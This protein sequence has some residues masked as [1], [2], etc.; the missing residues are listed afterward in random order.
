MLTFGSLFSKVKLVTLELTYILLFNFSVLCSVYGFRGWNLIK[1]SD[2]VV[3]VATAAVSSCCF[4]TS[5]HGKF[6][7]FLQK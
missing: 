6:A 2:D 4:R 1:I 3:F 7:N 5:K